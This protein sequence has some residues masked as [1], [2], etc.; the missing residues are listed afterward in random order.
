MK[1][2]RNEQL[3]SHTTFGV[4]ANADAFIVYDS[5][6]EL[7][8]LLKQNLPNIYSIGEG[9]NLLFLSDFHGTLL[10]SNILGIECIREEDDFV[11]LR[12]GAGEIWDEFVQYCVKNDLFGAEN[13][14]LIPG[15]V[16]ATPVQNIGA[17]GVEAKD[18]IYAV[19]CV[20]R[21]GN[22]VLLNN[23]QCCFGYRDSAFKRFWSNDYIVTRVHFRLSRIPRWKLDYGSI[24]QSLNDVPLTLDNVRQAIIKTRQ[25]KLP[26]PA[27]LGNAGSFFK[28][29][30]VSLS[31]F[32]ELQKRL[33]LDIPHYNL[34]D[35]QVKIP[36]AFLIERCGWKGRSLGSAA[37]HDRQPLVLVNKGNAT[38]NDILRLCQSIQ[39]DVKHIFNIDL[40]PE[41]IFL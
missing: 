22:M 27:V 15:S 17:Y 2:L 7:R 1:V 29:P 36:A 20:D 37:V 35:S 21:N 25:S 40:K 33:N 10:H 18:L 3:Q 32:L 9:A 30:V 5:E 6:Q 19:E 12:V 16:G 8:D 38:G 11:I 28:N 39:S 14:S 41:V 34:P 4:Y 26:D 31:F 23:E 13:L 24:R